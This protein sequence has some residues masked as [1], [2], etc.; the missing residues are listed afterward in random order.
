MA[1]ETIIQKGWTAFVKDDKCFGYQEFTREGKYYG[2]LTLIN[3]PTEA[4]LLTEL[5]RLKIS[6]P[7]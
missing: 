4:Q 2:V 6:L 7:Q 5:K 3:K 1:S